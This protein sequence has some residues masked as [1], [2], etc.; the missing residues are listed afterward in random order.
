MDPLAPVVV[1]R[2]PSPPLPGSGS[3]SGELGA[4]LEQPTRRARAQRVKSGVSLIR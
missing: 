1:V 2:E 3:V 4:S